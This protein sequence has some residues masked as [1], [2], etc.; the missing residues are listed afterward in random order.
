M[1]VDRGVLIAFGAGS[2]R[3][4]EIWIALRCAKPT[5]DLHV[6]ERGFELSIHQKGSGF[7]FAARSQARTSKQHE[8]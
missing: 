2:S 5:D 6:V 8:T 1:D 3:E 7:P 4:N